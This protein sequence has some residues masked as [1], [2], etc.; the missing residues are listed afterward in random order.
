MN[1][2]CDLSDVKT[3]E[4]ENLLELANELE[5]HP[6]PRALDGKVLALLFLNPSL[7]T[8]TS[9]Q[10]SMTRLGGGALRERDDVRAGRAVGS[11]YRIDSSA[12][13]LADR[14]VAAAVC[15]SLGVATGHPGGRGRGKR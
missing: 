9:F 1:E 15:G 6:R 3:D 10:A 2:F 11:A 12:S 5:Q 8:L 13:P 4:I 7:R 14:R